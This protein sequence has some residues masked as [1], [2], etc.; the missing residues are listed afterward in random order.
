MKTMQVFFIY[1]TATY[2]RPSRGTTSTPREASVTRTAGDHYPGAPTSGDAKDRVTKNQGSGPGFPSER[3]L[4]FLAPCAL[5]VYLL[6]SLPLLPSHP[7][8]NEGAERLS[9][10]VYTRITKWKSDP[11]K[12]DPAPSPFQ[13]AGHRR[14]DEGRSGRF[15]AKDSKGQPSLNPSPLTTTVFA[16]A[17]PKFMVRYLAHPTK[18][19]GPP[20]TSVAAAAQQAPRRLDRVMPASWKSGPIRIGNAGGCAQRGRGCKGHSFFLHVRDQCSYAWVVQALGPGGC[21]LWSSQGALREMPELGWRWQKYG[22]TKSINV[23]RKL[24]FSIYLEE[25]L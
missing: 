12:A 19:S 4:S 6:S 24:T 20:C 25:R 9:L 1:S 8:V 18:R 13:G 22:E 3:P 23:F 11:A 15:P 17:Y 16:S 10:T 14:L 21:G 7:E 5:T 2:W